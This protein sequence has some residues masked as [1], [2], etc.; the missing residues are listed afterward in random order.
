LSGNRVNQADFAAFAII[1][2]NVVIAFANDGEGVK[3]AD[4]Y[5]G[6]PVVEAGEEAVV[7]PFIL[8]L[9]KDQR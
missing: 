4:G 6:S 1:Q 5:H 7:L 2:I 8:N 9:S 3:F